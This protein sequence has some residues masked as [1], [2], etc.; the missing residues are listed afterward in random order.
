MGAVEKLPDLVPD[1]SIVSHEDVK[2]VREHRAAALLAP[3]FA[4]VPA[5]TAVNYAL[6]TWFARKWGRRVERLWTPVPAL[7]VNQV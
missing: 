2:S 3:L 6:E 1:E 4:L 7:S 5:I